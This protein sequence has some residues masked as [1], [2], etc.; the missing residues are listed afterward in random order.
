MPYRNASDKQQ[1]EREHREQRNAKRRRRPLAAQPGVTVLI[2]A[3]DP[4]FH[5]GTPSRIR[6]ASGPEDGTSILEGYIVPLLMVLFV[7]LVILITF[8][9]AKKGTAR[10]QPDPIPPNEPKGVLKIAGIGAGVFMVG[11][12]VYAAWAGSFAGDGGDT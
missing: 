2:S 12:I 3:P 1:W 4:R 9:R 11:L 6:T 7:G 8:A 10:L 5:K